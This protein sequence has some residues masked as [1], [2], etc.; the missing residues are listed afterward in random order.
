MIDARTIVEFMSR[1][2]YQPVSLRTLAKQMQITDAE[3]FQELQAAVSELEASGVIRR[4]KKEGL[5]LAHPRSFVI[6]TIDVKRRGFAFVRPADSEGPDIY[7]GPHSLGAALDGDLVLVERLRHPRRGRTMLESAKVVRVLERRQRKLVGTLKG[8]RRRRYVVPDGMSFPAEIGLGTSDTAGA[9]EGDKVVIELST[10][11]SEGLAGRIIQV[12]GDGSDPAVDAPMVIT[13]FGLRTEFP[14]EVL[15]EVAGLPDR[16]LPPDLSGRTDLRE[17]VI[18]TIDPVTAQDFDD[19]ISLKRTHS[20]WKLGVHIADV[21]HY[22]RPQTAVWREAAERATSV[23]LPT[24]TIPMLPEKL[25]SNLCS[26]R[27]K[28][29]RLTLSVSIDLD[30]EGEVTDFHIVRSVIRS[31]KRLTYEEASAAIAPTSR[32]HLDGAV[33]KLLKESARLAEL[34]SAIRRKRGALELEL[35]EVELEYDEKGYVTGAHPL[36]RDISHRLI[37]EFMLLANEC[38]ARY[39]ERHGR[40]LIHRV[41]AP[42]DARNLSDLFFF[43]RT[44]GI[45]PSTHEPRRALQNILAKVEG[46]PLSH[47]VNLVVLKSMKHAEYLG[48]SLGHYALATDCYCHFTSPIRRFPDLVVHSV[49]K[50]FD[51][52][53]G[54]RRPF[55][56]SAHLDRY[57]RHSSEMEE[58]S[59]RA[60]REVVKIK[61]LRFLQNRVGETM[62]GVVVGVEEFGA[63]VELE[64]V[65]VDGLI[66][67]RSL[68][69]RVE[70]DARGHTLTGTHRKYRLRLGDRVRVVIHSVD[71]ERRELDL[72]WAP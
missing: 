5:A 25:S 61:L 9:R 34:R 50:E 19:A 13:Q 47:A 29:D 15:E 42:P 37:E 43:A 44:L 66:S 17:E 8:W 39:G 11:V 52:E 40:T 10:R 63:F 48:E 49:L 16:V 23:Y 2:G 69:G 51:L 36:K 28:E 68:G 54:V 12:L 65:P 70:H 41:H 56:W 57:A 4:R 55:D 26:L 58:L 6:G 22:V 7:V 72:R 59:E 45:A 31:S 60:E 53:K 64:E 27:P 46:T 67:V 32:G 62:H 24:R 38:V 3:G 20:G 30:A 35:P 18:V 71:L 33:V 14:E 1:K 21:S